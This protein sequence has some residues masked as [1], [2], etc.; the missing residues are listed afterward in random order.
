MINFSYYESVAEG[1]LEFLINILQTFIDEVPDAISN[2]EKA[3]KEGDYQLSLKIIHKLKPSFSHLNIDL[4]IFSH[5]ELHNDLISFNDK[6]EKLHLLINQ[7]INILKHQ[8]KIYQSKII[9]PPL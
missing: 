9:P 2:L 3:Y 8:I 7:V 1:D 6:K 4:S 5:F